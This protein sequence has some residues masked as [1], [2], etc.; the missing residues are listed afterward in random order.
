MF[1]LLRMTKHTVGLIVL[2]L[3]LGQAVTAQAAPIT[4]EFSG[5]VTSVPSELGGTF[6]TGDALTGSYTFESS[7]SDL[8]PLS[9]SQG[10]YDSPSGGMQVT[11]G[12]STASSTGLRIGVLDNSI[13]LD[14][15]Q[16]VSRVGFSHTLSGASVS[17]FDL[18]QLSFTLLDDT[19]TALNSDALPLMPPNLSDFSTSVFSLGFREASTQSLKF[20]NGNLTS[21]TVPTTK[22]VPEPSTMLLLGTG[23]VGLVGWRWKQRKSSDI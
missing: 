20:V 22:P 23:L 5:S 3:V 7:A 6:S 12:T 4:F 18:E 1:H 16:F 15:Y 9:T 10:V 21:I 13:G 14:A 8:T 2:F 19:Q 17:G 11:I